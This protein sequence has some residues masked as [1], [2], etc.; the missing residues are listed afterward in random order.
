MNIEKTEKIENLNLIALRKYACPKISNQKDWYLK[1]VD[2]K[3]LNG[4]PAGK[5]AL[6]IIETET[7]PQE[8]TKPMFDKYTQAVFDAFRDKQGSKKYVE[9]L[10]KGGSDPVEYLVSNGYFTVRWRARDM[11]TKWLDSHNIPRSLVPKEKDVE[12]KESAK[13]ASESKTYL[14]RAKIEQLFSG[15]VNNME[16]ARRLLDAEENKSRNGHAFSQRCRGWGNRYSDLDKKFDFF[17]LSKIFGCEKY[18]NMA[19]AQIMEDLFPAE[20]QEADEDEV[21][22]EDFLNEGPGDIQAEAEEPEPAPEKEPEP[23]KPAEE[24]KPIEPVLKAVTDAVEAE[25]S[26]IDILRLEFGMKRVQLKKEIVRLGVEIAE[27]AK[28]REDL[29]AQIQTLDSAAEL[30]GLRATKVI[31]CAPESQQKQTV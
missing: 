3:G 8:M 15:T 13:N 25:N 29:V 4:C 30:F 5:R 23:E 27:I 2:C 20:K 31:D 7:K 21:S 11:L 17:G 19:V 1:C 18:R 22:I 12:K 24:K 28:K 10:E 16:R 26:R 14:T 9:A 6:E